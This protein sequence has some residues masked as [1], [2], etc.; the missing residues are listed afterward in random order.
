[1]FLLLHPDD[2]EVCCDDVTSVTGNCNYSK[3][4]V[5]KDLSHAVCTLFRLNNFNDWQ[6]SELMKAV[7]A[8]LSLK[9]NK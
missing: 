4:Q 9:I 3:Q 2:Y 1:M 7:V 5:N 8:F 6:L